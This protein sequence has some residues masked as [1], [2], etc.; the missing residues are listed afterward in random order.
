MKSLEVGDTFVSRENPKRSF[1]VIQVVREKNKAFAVDHAG[2]VFEMRSDR[3]KP[4]PSYFYGMTWFD[5]QK[6]EK[7]AS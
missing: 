3:L 5:L 1:L 6:K 4:G 2:R 7:K